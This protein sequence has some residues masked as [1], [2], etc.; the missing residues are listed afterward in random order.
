MGFGTNIAVLITVGSQSVT[1]TYSYGRPLLTAIQPSIGTTAGN[2]AVT[3]SGS[4]FGA[5]AGSISIGSTPCPIAAVAGAWSHTQ[6]ICILPAGQGTNSI[7]SLRIGGQTTAETSIVFRYTAPTASSAT[8]VTGPTGGGVLITLVGANFGLSGIVT[9]GGVEC[10]W[11]GSSGSWSHTQVLCTLP[12]GSG[13]G[14]PIVLTVAS[15]TV[16]FSPTFS[17]VAPSIS[18]ISP[19]TGSTVGGT[20]VT[21]TGS[22][23]G[24][25]TGSR[26]I[27]IGGASCTVQSWS[28]TSIVCSTPA[29]Q[30]TQLPV[31]VRA[32]SGLETVT[33][34]FFSY[35]GPSL[36][37][38]ILPTAASTAGN[39]PI[40]LTGSNFGQTATVTVGGVSCPA[41]S[42]T[43]SEFICTLPPGV[44][45]NKPV[46]MD[47]VGQVSNTIQF[48]YSPPTLVSVSPSSAPS[49]GGSTIT[50]TGVSLGK[51]AD[52]GTVTFGS[53]TCIVQAWSDTQVTC[54]I[55]AGQGTG[56]AISV[57]VSSQSSNSLS[58]SYSVP[59]FSGMTP[60]FGLTGPTPSTA[61]VTLTGSSFGT[62][63]PLPTVSLGGRACAVELANHTTIIFK[64]PVGDGVS[65]QLV[66]TVA[67]QVSAANS[68]VLFSYLAPTISSINPPSAA[69]QGGSILTIAGSSLGGTTSNILVTVGGAPCSPIGSAT[70]TAVTCT[71][72]AGQGQNLPVV[73]TTAAQASA[74]SIVFSYDAPTF[75]VVSPIT[76]AFLLSFCF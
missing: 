73:V 51:Q 18:A 64:S 46:V 5:S 22:S 59:S 4:N 56:V 11:T 21:V 35:N 23:F 74:S 72:P 7:V 38:T 19:T 49:I 12:V 16:T 8:P 57:Q 32:A 3:L 25:D 37:P 30:G 43:S 60:R 44:G 34:L 15:Q 2:I 40:T 45:I 71:L 54:R 66:V 69:T 75:S 10:L 14:L 31:Y 61:V 55:P 62:G 58:F 63:S 9:I 29:G 41:V 50:V 28:H 39:T 17:Y 70:H 48:S 20:I 47:V 67:S 42:Q 76:G 65:L 13:S 68:A 24:A 33:P 27:T 26:I 53:G 52:G 1:S 36:S 6:A